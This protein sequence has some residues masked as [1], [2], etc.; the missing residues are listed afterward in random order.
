[1]ENYYWDNLKEEICEDCH[2][3][4][5]RSFT[6]SRCKCATYCGVDCQRSNWQE[7]KKVCKKQKK[8]LEAILEQEKNSNATEK[9][10][11]ASNLA[12]GEWEIRNV[13]SAIDLYKQAIDMD[14]PTV[15]GHPVA[16]LYLAIHYER[17]IGVDQDYSQALKLYKRILN[18]ELGGESTVRSALLACSRFYKQGLG[19]VEP[20]DEEAR[21]F[22]VFATSNIECKREF[23]HMLQWWEANKDKI[24]K[25]M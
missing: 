7:H 18:H 15:G 8:L 13:K 3:A 19:G 24:P 10:I 20:N 22:A 14:N 25:D 6:C 9:F 23:D 12:L 5:A 17:G 4:P 11:T 16:M 21:K 2:K 1:M